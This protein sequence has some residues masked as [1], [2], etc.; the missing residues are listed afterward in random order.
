MRLTRNVLVVIGSG[1]GNRSRPV[2]AAQR[3]ADGRGMWLQCVL[4]HGGQDH[5]CCPPLVPC[6]TAGDPG[7]AGLPVLLPGAQCATRHLPAALNRNDFGKCSKFV[8]IYSCRKCCCGRVSTAACPNCGPG[9]GRGWR[10]SARRRRKC[11]KVSRWSPRRPWNRRRH[12]RPPRPCRRR[13][14]AHAR[15]EVHGSAAA[16]P[17]GEARSVGE[18]RSATSAMRDRVVRAEVGDEV[19]RDRPQ[20][21]PQSS[22]RA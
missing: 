10:G 2:G 12:R 13:P 4:Q 6:L 18:A 19:A 11:R 7:H 5:G 16:A 20:A 8:P 14:L 21:E 1:V 17:C 15:H 22:R 3:R 9:N